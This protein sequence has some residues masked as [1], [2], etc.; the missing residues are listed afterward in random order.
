MRKKKPAGPP[1]K[2][3]DGMRQWVKGTWPIW[4]SWNGAFNHATQHNQID[5]GTD[6]NEVVDGGPGMPWLKTEK[7][8]KEEKKEA[9]K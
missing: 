4:H 2:Y 8:A 7:P 9:E 1:I 3:H 6:D 5:D